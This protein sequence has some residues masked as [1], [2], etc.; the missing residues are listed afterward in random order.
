MDPHLAER[1]MSLNTR[2]AL[3]SAKQARLARQAQGPREPRRRWLPLASAYQNLKAL[4]E[5]RRLA[6]HQ[7]SS[8]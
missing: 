2:E 3:A 1:E 6:R 4:L 5:Q 7:E 8:S